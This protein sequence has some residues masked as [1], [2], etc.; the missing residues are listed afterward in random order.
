MNE[1]IPQTNR[2]LSEKRS[3]VT[4]TSTNSFENSAGTNSISNWQPMPDKPSQMSNEPKV[5]PKNQSN[6]SWSATSGAPSFQSAHPQ[7]INLSTINTLQQGQQFAIGEWNASTD[8]SVQ[9][10]SDA[11]QSNNHAI[12]ANRVQIQQEL[13]EQWLLN[14]NW[15]EGSS[16]SVLLFKYRMC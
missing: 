15:R 16:G 3:T 5:V 7:T 8:S 4:S 9:A 10:A 11:S 13:H 1:N 2:Y 6:L 14:Q 12:E